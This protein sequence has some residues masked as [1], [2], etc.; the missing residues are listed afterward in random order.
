MSNNDNKKWE[1]LYKEQEKSDKKYNDLLEKWEKEQAVEAKEHQHVDV[2]EAATKIQQAW[3]NSKRNKNM[4]YGDVNKAGDLESNVGA[5]KLVKAEQPPTE[6]PNAPNQPVSGEEQNQSTRSTEPTPEQ[7]PVQ[8]VVQQGQPTGAVVEPQAQPVQPVVQQGQPEQPDKNTTGTDGNEAVDGNKNKSTIE[9]DPKEGNAKNINCQITKLVEES[10]DGSSVKKGQIIKGPARH[11]DGTETS[12]NIIGK[13]IHFFK[14]NNKG[15][16]EDYI[17]GIGRW[18]RSEDG[19]KGWGDEKGWFKRW[20]Y[21]LTWKIDDTFNEANGQLNDKEIEKFNYWWNMPRYK[22]SCNKM[23]NDFKDDY[24][25]IIKHFFTEAPEVTEEPEDLKDA[26]KWLNEKEKQQ[27]TDKTSD[28]KFEACKKYPETKA[29]CEKEDNK[30]K[31]YCKQVEAQKKKLKVTADKFDPNSSG[32]NK[33]RKRGKR[34][35]RNSRK[36]K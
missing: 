13:V 19:D 23:I 34:R 14:K 4:K 12:T 33:S 8:P 21:I 5:D 17:I 28:N 18:Y 26:F 7:Q 24:K 11:P 25:K 22:N 27:E 3:H 32:G 16:N 15:V 9:C 10:I 2:N 1:D 36:K 6:I 20:N 30:N 31:S 29:T 35:K